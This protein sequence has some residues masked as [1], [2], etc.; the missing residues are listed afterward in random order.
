MATGAVDQYEGVL[1]HARLVVGK[2]LISLQGLKPGQ[3]FLGELGWDLISEFNRRRAGPRRI[4]EAEA[5]DQA[6]LA[7]EV[8]GLLEIVVRLAGKPHDQIRGQGQ[9]RASV[10]QLGNDLEIASSGIT[11]PHR[12]EDPVR[13]ALHRKMDVGTE[14]LEVAV[15]ADQIGV[16]EEWVWAGV[17][18]PIETWDRVEPGEEF[19][20]GHRPG[21]GCVPTPDIVAPVGIHRLAQERD[22]ENPAFSEGASLG[23]D[24][25]GRAADLAAAGRGAFSS[26]GARSSNSYTARGSRCRCPSSGALGERLNRDQACA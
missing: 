16:E 8:E 20:E 23:L 12:F 5:V 24:L 21:S 18:D 15:G 25:G 13:A 3:S 7:Y 14:A 2:C 6:S 19:C 9:I 1:P 11:T 22:L 4:L 26:I 17:A 10:A